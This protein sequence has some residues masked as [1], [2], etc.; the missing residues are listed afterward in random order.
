MDEETFKKKFEEDKKEVEGMIQKFNEEVQRF[1]SAIE[2]D[3][4]NL[5]IF[6]TKG[7]GDFIIAGGLS[8]AVQNRK[9][10][11]STILVIQDTK[12]DTGILFPN[13]TGIISCPKDF[14]LML[15][16]H[17]KT[18]ENYESDNYIYAGIRKHN[19]EYIWDEDLN[20]LER[21]KKDSLNI[22]LDTPFNYPIIDEISADNAAALHE[23]YILDKE[24][25]IIL[26]PHAKTF[27]NLTPEFW[28]EVAQRLKEKNYIVYTNVAG[29]EKPVKGT[30]PL[31]V[32][33]VELYYLTDKV[34][35]F[36]GTNSGVFIFLAMTDAKTINVTPFP[37]WYWDISFMFP[38]CNNRT[39]YDT[40]KYDSD[41]KSILGE[42]DVAAKV[43]YSHEKIP[44]ENI[45]NSHA[46]IIDEILKEVEKI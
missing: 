23:K 31:K 4:E 1:F 13:V 32:S 45:F 16:K 22:P 36:I 18:T 35:L 20:M 7:I 3:K 15:N 37:H 43:K 8:Y 17:F 19:D 44:Q 21:Y 46:E 40:T 28:E 27:E 9:G 29:N 41:M 11:K 38:E 12:W 10:K 25:T 33:F 30:E 39:L 42:Y 6:S 2:D 5:Y 24:R 34:K 14:V 26:L